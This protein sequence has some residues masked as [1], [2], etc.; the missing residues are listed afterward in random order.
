MGIRLPLG[1][2]HKAQALVSPVSKQATIALLELQSLTG[3]L[4]FE[5]L[6]IPLGRTFLRRLY[7]LQIYFPAQSPPCRRGISREAQK[8]LRW[9]KG[10]HAGAQERSIRKELRERVYLWSNV[11]GSKGLGAYYVDMRQ[12]STPERCDNTEYAREYLLKPH[13]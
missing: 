11:A 12:A 4:N 2:L 5:A 8:D 3:E 7:N 13:K 6:V 10:I 9:W 1:K